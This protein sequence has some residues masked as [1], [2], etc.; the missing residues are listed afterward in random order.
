MQYS[1]NADLLRQVTKD[2]NSR[3]SLAAEVM[4]AVRALLA[5]V[6]MTLRVMALIFLQFG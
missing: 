6:R 1:A 3:Q 4:D 2:F 5:T